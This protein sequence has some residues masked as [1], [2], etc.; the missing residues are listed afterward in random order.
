MDY[1]LVVPTEVLVVLLGQDDEVVLRF[2]DIYSEYVFKCRSDLVTA[3]VEIVIGDVYEIR[4]VYDQVEHFIIDQVEILEPHLVG[5]VEVVLLDGVA[6]L[7]EDSL[8]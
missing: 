2:A 6:D 3:Q 7:L 1:L 8:Y 4:V 5:T